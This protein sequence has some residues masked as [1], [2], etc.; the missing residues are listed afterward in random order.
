MLASSR[1][2]S[3]FSGNDLFVQINLLMMISVASQSMTAK[4]RSV[5]GVR[6]LQDCKIFKSE[7]R[8]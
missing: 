7:S 6:T 8:N 4:P 5:I 2:D 3:I 1:V